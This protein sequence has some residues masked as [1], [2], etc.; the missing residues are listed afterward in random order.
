MWGT[1]P[2]A[3]PPPAP[4]R[5]RDARPP[6]GAGGA[7]PEEPAASPLLL[8]GVPGQDVKGLKEML[9]PLGQPVLEAV[10]WSEELAAL[11]DEGLACILVD[12]RQDWS[13]GYETAHR[14]RGHE[15]ARHI[16]LL[17]L[18]G[19]SCGEADVLRGYGLGMVDCLMEP[20]QPE[21]LR[22][23]V[24]MIIELSRRERAMRAALE[25]AGHAEAAA[26][27]SE[28]MLLTLLGNMPGMAYRCDNAPGYPMDYASQGALRL[29]G[30]GPEDFIARRVLW[31]EL[32]HPEDVQRVWENIQAAVAR[33][34]PFT[35][36]YRLR[37]R[38]GEERWV[39]ERGVVLDEPSGGQPLLEG[40]ISDITALHRAEEERERLLAQAQEE[41]RRLEAILQQLPCAV[42]IAEAPSGRTLAVNARS[43]EL[44][45]HPMLEV[46]S[47]A[48]YARYHAIHPDGSRYAAEEYPIVRVLLTGKA[49]PEQELLYALPDGAVR[50]FLI[51]AG[52]IFDGHGRLQAAVASFIDITALKRAEQHQAFLASVSET[53]A[54]S[55]DYEG[56]LAH[57]VQRAV[58]ALGDGCVL[59]M[60]EPDGTLCRLAVSHVDPAR[61]ELAWEMVRRYPLRPDA[62]HGPGA[63]LRTGHSVRVNDITDELTTRYAVDA[64]HLELLR[65]MGA[66]ATLVVPLHA[67]G[68]TFGVLTLYYYERKSARY[69][70]EDQRLAEDLAHRA[71]L[72]VDNAR[73]YREAQLAVQLRDEFLSVASHELKTPLTP[74]SLKLSA[75]SREL[76][77]CGEGDPRTQ[78]LQ[79]HVDVA[80]RQVHKMTTLINALL[81]VSRLSQ[82]KL[83]LELSDVDLG[84]VLGEVVAWF[85]PE[86]ARLGSQLRME[87]DTHV[88]G[89]WDRL[90]LEQVV[91]NL[92]S[93]AIRYGAGRPIHARVEL[94]GGLARLVVRDEGIGIAPEAQERIFGKFERAVSDR[95]AAGLGLGLYITRSIVEALGGSIR[96]E[97]RPGEGSTFTVE[98][99]RSGPPDARP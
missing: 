29:T 64:Q 56:T 2:E 71:A 84:E 50:T 40:F 79:R 82:G 74:L 55:L 68:R 42:H 35:F 76:P 6:S 28:R 62:P 92:V 46:N 67:R 53:L 80:R 5:P 73:L 59:D 93:N 25:R 39:W 48:D 85:A 97:S 41:H 11:L 13:V 91:T 61:A 1:Q 19:N 38:T 99:P 34:S 27:E 7:R 65:D 23:K 81:D 26:R 43:E 36:I 30:Y 31:E 95:H 63:V 87:G 83:K 66:T 72:A 18:G 15:G 88:P 44:L 8:V 45:G 47:T 16:P 57:V 70:A 54:S 78:A 89:R 24:G 52:P 77:R 75:L 98:L 69:S 21:V 9:A 33:R 51:S 60:L 86:A 14:L 37:T 20:V 17:F 49:Q 32:I 22:A 10:P 58:P 12:A 4:G 96:V 94:D 90:R 3:E